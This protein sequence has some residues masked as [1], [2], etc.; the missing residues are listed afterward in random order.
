MSNTSSR[1]R[2]FI[3]VCGGC[4]TI[5]CYGARPPLSRERIGIIEK[6]LRSS[7]STLELYEG[8]YCSPRERTDGSCSLFD[9]NLG[10]C[11]VHQVK[12]E[13]CLAGPITFDINTRTGKMEWYLKTKDIC[14]LAGVMAKDETLL[15]KHLSSARTELLHLVGQLEGS[16]LRA[17]L[18]IE[19]ENTIKIGEEILPQ[20]ILSK[21]NRPSPSG[22]RVSR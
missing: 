16:A 8:E 14:P 12:P 19:E 5:C 7:G 13:T 11:L 10:Q 2:D 1:Q 3:K 18:R 20:A 17:I 4:K 9:T 6:H 22:R 21:L 15:N